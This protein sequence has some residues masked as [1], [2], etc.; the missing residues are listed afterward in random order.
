M[1]RRIEK[2]VEIWLSN[3]GQ[4]FETYDEAFARDCELKAEDYVTVNKD[5]ALLIQS[6]LDKYYVP[7]AALYENWVGTSK[8]SE[9]ILKELYSRKVIKE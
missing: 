4:E 6:V 9:L 1:A 5:N 7:L 8:L 3:D 2:T